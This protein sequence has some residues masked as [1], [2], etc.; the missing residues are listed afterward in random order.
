MKP[1][2]IIS[3][4][5]FAI[6]LFT[7][8]ILP[9]SPKLSD[10]ELKHQIVYKNPLKGLHSSDEDI[11]L[12]CAFS[13]GK[14]KS[15]KAVLPLMKLLRDDPSDAVRIVAAQSLIEIGDPRGIFLVG[16]SAKFNSSEHVRTLCEKFYSY[17]EF[18]Q[19]LAKLSESSTEEL[20]MDV[21]IKD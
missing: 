19:S 15:E 8:I 3:S 21:E 1:R 10:D 13:L 6:L 18:S 14:I 12:D 17:H 7:T 20:T 16:R 4:I 9:Q 2:F 11:R 5:V